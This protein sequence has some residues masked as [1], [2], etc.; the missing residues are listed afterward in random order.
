[1]SKNMVI[2]GVTFEVKKSVSYG[3]FCKSN[4]SPRRNLFDCYN[5][6]SQR[7]V[8]IWSEWCEWSCDTEGASFPTVSSYNVHRFTVEMTYTDPETLNQYVL[9]ITQVHNRA[10]PVEE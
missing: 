10:Y 7:K 5:R 3:D 6:P 4:L 9:E 8:N 1:M 2:N